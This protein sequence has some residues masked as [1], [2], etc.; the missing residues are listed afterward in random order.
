MALDK[1]LN[2]IQLEI[3]GLTPLLELFVDASVQPSVTDCENLQKH[4]NQLEEHLAVYKYM[5]HNKEISPSYNLHVKVSEKDTEARVMKETIEPEVPVL[6]VPK[7]QAETKTS[8]Q[9]S[10]TAAKG[11]A[12]LQI[13]INDKFRFINE[14]FVQNSGEYNIA[15]EQLSNLRT[16]AE[17]EMYISSLKSLYNWKENADVTT[18]FYTL[19]KKR[20]S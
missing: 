18:Q 19:V 3:D 15:I 4:I 12:P 13:G 10:E 5:K 9:S 7:P 17:S 11:L 14:L 6:E 16:W 8:K 20:F 2:K 1:V